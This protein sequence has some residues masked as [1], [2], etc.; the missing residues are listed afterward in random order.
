MKYTPGI[1]AGAEG[2]FST[3]A[4]QN[5]SPAYR[6]RG[7]ATTQ[8]VDG[9]LSNSLSAGETAFVERIEAVNGPASV[10]YGQVNPGGMIATSLKKP[11]DTPLH[12]ASVGFGNW[13]RYEATFDVSDKVT[14]SGNIRYRVAAIGVTQGTQVDHVNYHRVGILPSITWD[15]D[16]N[17]SLTLLGSYMYTP[18]TGSSTATQYPIIGSLIDGPN[19]RISRNTFLSTKNWNVNSITDAMFE[20]QFKHKFNKYINFSQ[21]F[22]YENSNNNV[23]N[24]YYDGYKSGYVSVAPEWIR[25]AW[26]T[27]A[28]DTRIFGK[29]DTGAVKHTWVVGSD[30]QNYH[31]N[32]FFC[33]DQVSDIVMNM[34]NPVGSYSPCFSSNASSGC[35]GYNTN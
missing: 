10:M 34:Y 21:S 3:G 33:R 14:K 4:A 20:Y 5:S 27:E 16:R 28:I 32:W 7:F 6:Q 35:K 12:Q 19:G 29:F 1:Y 25:N 13:G 11:T 18:G 26:E 22:R 30:F 2:F 24:T 9:L 17:T 31:E 23:K 8:F 15:I